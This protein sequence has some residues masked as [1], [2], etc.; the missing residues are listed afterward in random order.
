MAYDISEKAEISPKAKIGNNC[1]I[2]PFVYIE[3][4]VVIGDNCVIYPFVSILKG[5]RL[6]CN[7]T[8]HQCSVMGALPQDFEF[9]GEDTEL[10][11]GNNNI[12]RENVVINRATHAGG[13]TLSLIHISEPTR[14]DRPSRMPS[15]A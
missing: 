15:S 5:T 2:F 1:K 8:V 14:Q 11:I 7:N 6:G 13:Q 4:D 3:E 12:I 9:K 10:I